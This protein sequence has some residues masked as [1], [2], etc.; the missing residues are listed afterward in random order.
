M[1]QS[2]GEQIEQADVSG[3]PGKL[4]PSSAMSLDGSWYGKWKNEGRM[5]EGIWVWWAN[6]P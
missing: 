5:I 2:G 6:W 1:G 3:I 4:N